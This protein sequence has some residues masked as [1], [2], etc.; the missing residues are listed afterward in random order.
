MGRLSRRRLLALVLLAALLGGAKAT[1]AD[2]YI[3]GA[4][5]LV[6]QA[7]REGEFVRRRLDERKLCELVRR[8]AEGRLAAAQ[9]MFV[10]QEVALAHPHLL[11]MLEHYE[12]AAAAAAAGDSKRALALLGDA[13]GDAELF[14]GILRQLGFPLSPE[15]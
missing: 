2:G 13:E 7:T 4:A 11:L 10:P 1:Q 3:E 6:S 9:A 5:L 14:R 12:R 15:K 8:I